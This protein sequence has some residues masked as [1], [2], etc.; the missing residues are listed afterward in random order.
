MTLE[1]YSNNLQ[2]VY[3]LTDNL[4]NLVIAPNGIKMLLS[5]IN[6][7]QKE[8]KA[9]SGAAIGIYDQKPAYFAQSSFVKS[10]AFAPIGK[11]GVNVGNKLIPAVKNPKPGKIYKRYKVVVSTTGE[12]RKSMYLPHGYKQ[13]REIQ[14]F[15]TGHVDQT[16]SG[17][18]MYDY[19]AA[20]DATGMDLGFVTER[21]S[22]IRR[23][24]EA[25]FKQPIYAPT[26]AEIAV[27]S[28]RVNNRLAILTRNTIQ[29]IS[30]ESTVE[31]VT[32]A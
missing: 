22:R 15:Q 12:K 10:G 23:G 8:G 28:E 24:Q 17:K 32:S 25:H 26:A 19:R 3:G 11:G 27:Y 31:L 6:R 7:I 16:L 14:G 5:I 2:D 1:E 13:F 4:V 9:S 29:G 21:S 18:T 30:P 20:T